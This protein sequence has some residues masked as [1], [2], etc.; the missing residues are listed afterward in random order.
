MYEHLGLA[1]IFVILALA[2]NL[3]ATQSSC[4]AAEPPAALAAQASAQVTA[5]SGGP[6]WAMSRP[7]VQA[8]S[9]RP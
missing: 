6:G 3:G 5:G 4:C 9:V 8:A 1:A 2:G 7:A